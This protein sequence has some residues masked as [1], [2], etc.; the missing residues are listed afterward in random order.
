MPNEA[1]WP[2]VRVAGGSDDGEDAAVAEDV[3][4]EE[5]DE[6]PEDVVDVHG[7]DP[8]ELSDED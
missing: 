8:K 2:D 5:L 3:D 1:K 7:F 4:D 6:T